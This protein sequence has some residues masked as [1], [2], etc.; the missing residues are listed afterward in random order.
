MSKSR[1]PTVYLFVNKDRASASLSR[2]HGKD[3]SAILSHV[4]SCRNQKNKQLHMFRVE[5]TT[6]L[7]RGPTPPSPRK[8]SVGYRHRSPRSTPPLRSETPQTPKDRALARPSEPEPGIRS[9]SSPSPR[10][11]SPGNSPEVEELLQ[12]FNSLCL[13]PESH[14]HSQSQDLFTQIVSSEDFS[15]FSR[16]IVGGIHG[17]AMLACTAARMGADMPS[18]R[19]EF[20]IKATKYMQPSLQRLREQLAGPN[21]RTLTDRQILQEMLLHCVTNWYLQD[22]TAAQTHLKA[23]HC[24]TGCLDVSNGSDRKLMAIIN[25]CGL[26]IANSIRAG[27]KSHPSSCQRTQ[28]FAARGLCRVV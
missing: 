18:R 9:A 13:T 17:Y 14:A 19:E 25:R 24:F 16:R 21:T 2:C 10:A 12:Y 28:S 11:T 8:Q 5:D 7:V 22:L 23:I 4:Q 3:A 26:F 6:E 1:H 20:E 15:N 27:Q